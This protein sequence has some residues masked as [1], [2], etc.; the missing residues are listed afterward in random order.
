MVSILP[1]LSRSQDEDRENDVSVD[2][3]VTPDETIRGTGE[4]AEYY[5]RTMH[6][7]AAGAVPLATNL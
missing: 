1:R 5:R 3:I 4:F 7:G 2:M 6:A